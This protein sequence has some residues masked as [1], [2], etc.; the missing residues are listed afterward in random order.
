MINITIA[1]I[2]DG[3]FCEAEGH[4]MYAPKG[5]D[6]VCAGVSAVLGS[7][8]QL[9]EMLEAEGRV[10]FR[11]K[12]VSDGYMAF[13][14]ESAQSGDAVKIILD[15]VKNM[16]ITGLVWLEEEYPDHIRLEC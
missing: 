9:L 2:Y 11:D 12:A 4:A 7:A 8:F 16:L 10:I 6:I 1:E 3:L 13:E 5:E 15:T 14:V